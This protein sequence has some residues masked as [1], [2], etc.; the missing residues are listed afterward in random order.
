MKVPK[1]GGAEGTRGCLRLVTVTGSAER[2]VNEGVLFRF[3][4]GIARMSLGIIGR[5]S[6]IDE[7]W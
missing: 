4:G 3:C 7:K 6:G 1:R 5:V 2:H